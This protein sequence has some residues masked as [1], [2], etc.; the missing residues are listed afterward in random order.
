MARLVHPI[1]DVEGEGGET[2]REKEERERERESLIQG[3][4]DSWAF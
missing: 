4:P 2:E 1:F 3:K